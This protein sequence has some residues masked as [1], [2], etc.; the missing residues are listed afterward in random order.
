MRVVLTAEAETDLEG[1]GDYIATDNPGRA[2]TFVSEL[3]QRC[4]SLAEMPQAFPLLQAR[5]H[6]GIRRRPYGS[7]AIFYRVTE[8]TVEILHI[9]NSAQDVDRI[10]FSDND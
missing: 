1:I 9:L 10:L 2:A 4:L 5:A 3:V 7:Y 6:T 8:D